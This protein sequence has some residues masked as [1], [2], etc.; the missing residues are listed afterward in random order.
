[1]WAVVLASR[2]LLCSQV[3]AMLATFFGRFVP[4]RSLLVAMLGRGTTRCAQTCTTLFPAH[5][6]VAPCVAP[7]CPLYNEITHARHNA[8]KF[9]FYSRLIVIF[10][11]SDELPL[12]CTVQAEVIQKSNRHRKRDSGEPCRGQAIVRVL[13]ER[14]VGIIYLI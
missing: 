4:C 12:R 10:A 7:R 11:F 3:A 14:S 2:H 13:F 9:A 1:M 8:N 5:C 6:S